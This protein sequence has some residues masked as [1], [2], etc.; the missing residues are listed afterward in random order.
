MAWYARLV[1]VARTERM[2]E[3]DDDF[4]APGKRGCGAEA[5]GRSCKSVSWDPPVSVTAKAGSKWHQAAGSVPSCVIRSKSLSDETP[6]NDQA[7][8]GERMMHDPAVSC[9]IAEVHVSPEDA[10]NA[11]PSQKPSTERVKDGVTGIFWAKV[12]SR[13]QKQPPSHTGVKERVLGNMQQF[14]RKE[15][16]RLRHCIDEERSLQPASHEDVERKVPGS[17]DPSPGSG[18][19]QGHPPAVT[20]TATNTPDDWQGSVASSVSLPWGFQQESGA[21]SACTLEDNGLFF[22]LICQKDLSNM[23]SVRRMQHVNSCRGNVPCTLR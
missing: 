4:V 14:R 5:G 15:P 3:S 17:L 20:L 11:R 18:E 21:A 7:E 8:G 1:S 10:P 23:N 9:C 13:S 12:S 16:E 2:D 19:R 22:C 6:G